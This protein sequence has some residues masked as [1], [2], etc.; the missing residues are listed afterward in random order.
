MAGSAGPSIPHLP[1]GDFEL[2]HDILEDSGSALTDGGWGKEKEDGRK[3]ICPRNT[4]NT[5]KKENIK[6]K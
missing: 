5:R 3:E 6:R 1:S 2:V 4:R